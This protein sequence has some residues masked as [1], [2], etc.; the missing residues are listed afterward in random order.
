MNILIHTKRVA[1][2]DDLKQAIYTKIGRVAKYAPQALRARVH[3]HRPTLAQF[4]V[5]VHYEIPGRD[6]HAEHT[7]TDAL[8]ALDAV[9]EKI[10]RRLRKRKTSLL[11][12][13]ARPQRGFAFQR[14]TVELERIGP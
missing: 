4:I 5:R 13:R 11:A 3:L 12:R 6:L 10:E 8:T 9:A 1:L 14:G 7:A 2:D